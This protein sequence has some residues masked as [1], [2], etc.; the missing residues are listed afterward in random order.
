MI[1][2]FSRYKSHSLLVVLVT[3]LTLIS[4][5]DSTQQLRA[6]FADSLSRQSDHICVVDFSDSHEEEQVGHSN[7]LFRAYVSQQRTEI[8]RM[9]LQR[10]TSTNMERYQHTCAP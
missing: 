1:K 7:R 2:T 4:P 8:M 9:T 10:G 3:S 5:F 6:I